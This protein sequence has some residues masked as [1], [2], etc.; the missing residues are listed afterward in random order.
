M[1]D[2]IVPADHSKRLY[3]AATKAKFKTLYECPD[4]DHNQTWRIGGEKYIDAFREFFNKC[5]K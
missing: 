4:G 3:E 1:K 2:E 5:E